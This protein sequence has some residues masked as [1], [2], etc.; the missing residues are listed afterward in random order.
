LVQR[1]HCSSLS[2]GSTLWPLCLFCCCH[3]LAVVGGRPHS[4]LLAPLILAC[5]RYFVVALL[6]ETLPLWP[7]RSGRVMLFG[8][9]I[10]SLRAHLLI[11]GNLIN[12]SAN[13]ASLS[14]RRSFLPHHFFLLS[15]SLGHLQGS[16]G[17]LDKVRERGIYNE[18]CNQL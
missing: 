8:S 4:F 18:V 1:L 14:H 5:L 16:C 9:V 11:Q 2:A 7:K 13:M 10:L 12:C 17:H 6:G 15:A 3:L